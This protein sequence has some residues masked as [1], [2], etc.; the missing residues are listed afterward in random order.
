M[1]GNAI[2]TVPVRR[3]S[4][5]E[6]EALCDKV[7]RIFAEDPR[8]RGTRYE[9]LGHFDS[10]ESWGD[11]DILIEESRE[12]YQRPRPGGFYAGLFET[13]ELHENGPVISLEHNEFQIDFIETPRDEFDFASVYYRFND[14]GNLCGK[15]A[16]QLGL[17]YGF[18]GLD[19]VLR[20]GVGDSVG[21]INVT[22]NPEEALRFMGYDWD[23]FQKGFED[24]EELFQ[25]AASSRYFNGPSY[26][27]ENLN[28]V[29]RI[30]DRKRATYQ[31][32][33]TWLEEHPERK[34]QTYFASPTAFF[35]QIR[36]AFPEFA[37][38]Y[39]LL[40]SKLA[41]KS[42]MKMKFNGVIISELTGLKT[43]EL[44]IFMRC[45]R[46]WFKTED[47]LIDYV[48]YVSKETLA[49]AVREFHEKLL[50]Q[51]VLNG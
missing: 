12:S 24:L 29:D 1:G 20:D 16:R 26:A 18:R 5:E 50:Q 13:K 48:L 19:Y 31:A 21:V 4:R 9:I 49:T 39:D 35:P 28:H 30:R 45:F 11:C 46:E 38:E 3:Y 43:I 14:L 51:K 47:D 10:K 27:L 22:K 7:H 33:L 42:A 32:F 23:R 34:L 40:N 36:R 25:F 37:M 41:K 17:R 15:T 44:G 8:V 2:K 6:Y